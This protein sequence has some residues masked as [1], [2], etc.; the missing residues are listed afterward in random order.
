[1]PVTISLVFQSLAN[2]ARLTVSKHS[3][4]RAVRSLHQSWASASRITN[5]FNLNFLSGKRLYSFR[6]PR[7]RVS[8]VGSVIDLTYDS[9]QYFNIRRRG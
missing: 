7:I 8:A 9:K 5:L 6:L 4:S 2:A 3:Y 1:M